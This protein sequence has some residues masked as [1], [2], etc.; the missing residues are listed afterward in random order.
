MSKINYRRTILLS[1]PITWY[2]IRPYWIKGNR[3]YE[4]LPL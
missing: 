3:V 1:C 4:V 2:I